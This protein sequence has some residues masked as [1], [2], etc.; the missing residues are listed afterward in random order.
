MITNPNAQVNDGYGMNDRNPFQASAVDIAGD[1][2]ESL[3]FDAIERFFKKVPRPAR[4]FK[5]VRI[6]NPA[7][8]RYE[9]DLIVV[10]PHAI[11]ALEVKHWSGAVSEK[12]ADT[13]LQSKPHVGTE[14]EHKNPIKLLQ[15]KCDAL[16]IYLKKNSIHNFQDMPIHSFVI[17]TNPRA[18]FD[19]NIRRSSFVTIKPRIM[20]DLLPLLRPE[21]GRFEKMLRRL[22]RQPEPDVVEIFSIAAIIEALEHLPTWDELILHGG[23]KLRGDIIEFEPKTLQQDLV[24]TRET[25]KR[26]RIEKTKVSLLNSILTPKISWV[27]CDEFTRK[28][29]IRSAK[30]HLNQPVKIHVVG[31]VEPQNVA[32]EH[33]ELVRFGD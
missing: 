7:G 32:L 28:T 3:V 24:L 17:F 4:I 18:S 12:N 14:I 5:E 26:Y 20:H 25:S 30:L 8:G 16:K 31:Q 1:L 29:R 33:I 11:I 19:I 15:T 9:I 23:K 21:G 13:W 6:P 27:E 22:F 10:S 2:G